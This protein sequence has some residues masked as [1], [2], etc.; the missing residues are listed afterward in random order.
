MQQT[1]AAYNM[2]LSYAYAQ[3]LFL[4]AHRDLILSVGKTRLRENVRHRELVL[5]NH[6]LATSLFNLVVQDDV[7]S[8]TES[9]REG[10]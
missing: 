5:E 9:T 6:A 1:A 2:A 10:T 8:M 4:V 7:K 3:Q